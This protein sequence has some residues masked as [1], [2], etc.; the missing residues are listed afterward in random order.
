MASSLICPH[1]GAE[2]PPDSPYCDQSSTP[3][4]ERARRPGVPDGATAAS[5]PRAVPFA[6]ASVAA[7]PPPLPNTPSPSSTG[8]PAAPLGLAALLPAARVL[9]PVAPS[10]P[11]AAYPAAPSTR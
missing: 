9:L 6:T 4:H 8:P 7:N 5:T 3:R 11:P 2:N 1:G 10:P